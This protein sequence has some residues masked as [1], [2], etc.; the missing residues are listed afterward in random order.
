MQHILVNKKQGNMDN[1]E[2]KAK[3][4]WNY[5]F[6]DDFDFLDKYFETYFEKDNLII[7]FDNESQEV[8]YM[9]LII[10]LKCSL[11]FTTQSLRNASL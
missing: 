10:G 4:F 7:G 11:P 6:G 8:K 2:Q 9:T 1:I 5:I 3:E